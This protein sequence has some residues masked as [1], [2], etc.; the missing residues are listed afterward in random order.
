MRFSRTTTIALLLTLLLVTRITPPLLVKLFVST[1]FQM[2]GLGYLWGFAPTWAACLFCGAMFRNRWLAVGV[3]LFA[4]VLGDAA[5]WAISEQFS[6]GFGIVQ[7]TN[8][9]I[10]AALTVAGM[11]LPRT[12]SAPRLGGMCIGAALVHFVLSNFIVWLAPLPTHINMPA[13]PLSLEGL[14]SCYVMALPFLPASLLGT[15]AYGYGLFALLGPV[16]VPADSLEE[17]A[18]SV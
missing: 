11:F 17:N 12:P 9:V 18:A 8:Y 6:Q 15:L 2:S 16:Q 14:V 13:Y 3:P 10:I 1:G 4:Q 5:Y 7:M